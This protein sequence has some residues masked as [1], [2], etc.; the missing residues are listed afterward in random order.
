MK[1][2]DW[3][4]HKQIQRAAAATHCPTPAHREGER[5]PQQVN[6]PSVLIL[7]RP[8]DFTTSRL[9]VET[10]DVF[11]RSKTSHRQFDKLGCR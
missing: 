5:L 4:G 11:L 2:C 7:T 9:A 8:V 6:T 3:R 1:I 10:G